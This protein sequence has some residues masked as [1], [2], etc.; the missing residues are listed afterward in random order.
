MGSRFAFVGVH[1][2][3]RNHLSGVV[4]G[5]VV[6]GYEN[7]RGQIAPMHVLKGDTMNN[8]LAGWLSIMCQMAK[9]DLRHES[10]ILIFECIFYL[11]V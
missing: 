9:A 11:T 5:E 3:T 4:V 8:W 2:A 1:M 6:P 7:G 10:I